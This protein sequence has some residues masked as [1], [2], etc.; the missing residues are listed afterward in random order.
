MGRPYG[1]TPKPRARSSKANRTPKPKPEASI[2]IKLG[3]GGGP[4]TI[5]EFRIMVLQALAET[6]AAGVSHISRANLYFNP[7][8]EKGRIVD[9]VGRTPLPDFDVPRPRRSAAEEHGL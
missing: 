4:W 9:R 1:R 5:D 8:D 3:Y 6:A 2:R 7:V